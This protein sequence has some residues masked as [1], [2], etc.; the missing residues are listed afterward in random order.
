MSSSPS[1]LVLL[2]DGS[3]ELEFISITNPLRRAGVTV[4]V[5]F[6][7]SNDGVSCTCARGT[8]ISTDGPLENFDEKN[9][10]LLVLPGGLPGSQH[11][12]ECEKLTKEILVNRRKESRWIAAICAAPALV[13]ADLGIFNG[14]K[15]SHLCYPAPIFLEK[16]K[17]AGVPAVEKEEETVTVCVDEESKIVTSIGPGTALEFGLRLVGIL[18]GN[19]KMKEIGTG[20]KFQGELN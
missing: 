15:K 13:F 12:A 17:N 1:A 14:V 16:M 9:F 5:A 19:E 2:A 6:V 10:D 4:K 3:E 20:M 7:K 11:F 8:I 18:C